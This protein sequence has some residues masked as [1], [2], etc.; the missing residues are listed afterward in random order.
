MSY[1]EPLNC[2]YCK[3]TLPNTYT[4]YVCE[5]CGNRICPT[6]FSGVREEMYQGCGSKCERCLLGYLKENNGIGSGKH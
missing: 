6:C 3:Q 2:M 4:W 1:G 5:N